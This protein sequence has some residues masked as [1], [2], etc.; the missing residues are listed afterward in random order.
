MRATLQVYQMPRDRRT[1]E[2][3]MRLNPLGIYIKDFT[4]AKQL[5]PLP[6]ANR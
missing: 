5:D 1:T 6:G 3:Q 4:W 2:E